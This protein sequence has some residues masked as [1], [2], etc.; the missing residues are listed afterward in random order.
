MDRNMLY[1]RD[2]KQWSAWL[3]KNHSISSGVLLIFYKKHTGKKGISYVEALE[4]AIRFGWIDSTLRRID[5][6]KHSINFTPRKHSSVWSKKNKDTAERMIKE[7][8][9]APAGYAAIEEAKKRGLWEA[10]YTN[11]TKERMPSDLK[12]ALLRDNKAWS[13]FNEFANTYRNMYI[14]W[15][16]NAKTEE[17]RKKRINDVV[18]RSLIKKKPGI[19]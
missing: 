12:K 7:D 18:N 16:K 8:R 5:D 3:E 17:T 1:F 13:N 11:K 6:E 14:G 4:E 9:M 10:A 15:V 19:I 2:K